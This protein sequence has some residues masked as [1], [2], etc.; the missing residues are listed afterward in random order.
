M[1]TAAQLPYCP[2]C[3]KTVSVRSTTTCRICGHPLAP[4]GER[5]EPEISEPEPA[6][7]PPGPEPVPA[8]EPPAFASGPG[9]AAAF[10]S[11]PSLGVSGHRSASRGDNAL[12]GVVAAVFVG[13]LAVAG[14]LFFLRDDDGAE[15][16]TAARTAGG[17]TAAGGVA[18]GGGAP[19]AGS[20]QLGAEQGTPLPYPGAWTY[21]APDGVTARF[22]IRPTQ[23]GARM[24]IVVVTTSDACPGRHTLAMVP[25]SETRPATSGSASR[26]FCAPGG[27]EPA[28]PLRLDFVCDARCVVTE[29]GSGVTWERA[30]Q[31]MTPLTEVLD[32]P[33]ALNRCPWNAGPAVIGD[34][35]R[36]GEIVL[37]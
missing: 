25:G 30:G 28:L 5:T 36:N 3:E 1:P 14:W 17:D 35:R 4:P 33:G 12:N 31:L 15:Q 34:L 9:P 22:E 2:N 18:A 13:F 19:A 23:G 37:S 24:G 32:C 29:T 8:V 6:V 21:E 16:S 7:E 11:G 26:V 20:G 27:H 10:A